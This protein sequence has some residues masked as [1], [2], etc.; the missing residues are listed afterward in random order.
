[1]SEVNNPLG[2]MGIEFTE[3]ATPDADYMDKVFTDF[4]FSKLKKFKGKDIVYYNQHDIHFLLNNEREGFSA[5]FAKSHGPAICSMGWRVENA[6][7]AFEVAVER[8]A[9][10]ATDSTH[11]NLPYPAIYGIGDSLIYFIEQFGDKGSIY[12]SDFEDLNEQ[13][14]VEDKGFIRIDHLT[15][16]VYKGTMETWANFYKDVF[17]FTEVRYFD[18]KGQKTALLSYAL[19]SPCGTFSIPINEGKDNNNNQIDEYLNEYNGPGVQHLAFLTNDLV[20]SL[21]KLDQSTIATLDIIPEY[22]DTIFDRV[23]WV[24]EDKE[25]IRKHQIL[26]DSQ[27][28]NC[29]LLQIFSKNLFGPIFIEMIQRVD[30]GGF[31]EGN[32]QALFESIERDQERRGVI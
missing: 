10:P 30:D 27:S 15:N 9:K 32:F 25:K 7:K 13:N 28:E 8:G 6:Q 3:Y 29:Y 5:E 2:L 22:Y 4:G 23:P 17:G 11:K 1:M 31:G 12:E 21:D 24:K 18:I 19:K 20:S 26:V 14:I 16:N